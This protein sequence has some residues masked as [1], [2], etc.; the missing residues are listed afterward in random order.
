MPKELVV[1]PALT[2]RRDDIVF[3]SIPVHAY[4]T[5]LADERARH[6][7]AKLV[8][9]LRHMLIVREFETMLGDFKSRGAY[10]G[11]E[12][13]YKGPAHLSIGQEG[14]A[15][16][17]AMALA[18]EDHIFGSHRSHG[19]FIAKGLS[20]IERLDERQ[21]MNIMEMEQGG[22]VLSAVHRFIKPASEKALAESFMLFGFLSEIFMR[23]TLPPAS[24]PA[25]RSTRSSSARRG[26]QSPSPATARPAAARSPRR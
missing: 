2:R 15:V 9:L 12:F 11:I 22:R 13:A 3:A 24:P 20:A 26:S 6:G 14:A 8:R 7:D 10:A 1:D 16:G 19:E 17:A 5:L 25:P 23:S 18:P 21:L 4:A